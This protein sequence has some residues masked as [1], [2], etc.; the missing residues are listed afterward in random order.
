MSVIRSFDPDFRV[1]RIDFATLLDIQAEAEERGWA[2]R[3]SS[4]DALRGQVKEGSVLLRSLLREERG[5]EVRA[6]RCLAL[7]ASAEDSGGRIATIDVA[8]ARFA[9]LERIDRDPDVRTALARLF[10]L[11][12]GGISP[13]TKR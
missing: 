1:C 9:A 7:F 5:G 6:Y 10:T 2:T 13:I 11:A 4:S 8:P 3:W 12:A